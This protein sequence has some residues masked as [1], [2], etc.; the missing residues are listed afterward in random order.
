M[1][2]STYYTIYDNAK[3]AA[4]MGLPKHNVYQRRTLSYRMYEQGYR[5]GRS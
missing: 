5:D 1:H 2:S 3:L 4:E